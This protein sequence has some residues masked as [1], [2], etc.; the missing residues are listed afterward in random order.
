M[1]TQTTYFHQYIEEPENS[2]RQQVFLEE[3]KMEENGEYFYLN[4]N[5]AE[6]GMPNYQIGE[7]NSH[8]EV[9]DTL[10][11]LR[12]WR[13]ESQRDFLHI[14][15]SIDKG[16]NDL[17][18]QVC[19][20]QAQ[21][22]V[23]TKERN[24]LIQTVSNLSGEIAELCAKL[25]MRQP[26]PKI[27]DRCSLNTIKEESMEME[28]DDQQ[29]VERMSCISEAVPNM[30][31][32]KNEVDG[33]DDKQNETGRQSKIKVQSRYPSRSKLVQTGS[34][35]SLNDN[36]EDHICP[37]CNIAFTHLKSLRIHLKNM[38]TKHTKKRLN[39]ESPTKNEDG[40]GLSEHSVNIEAEEIQEGHRND[41]YENIGGDKKFKCRQ[42][43]YSSGYSSHIKQH[44]KAVHEK[45][46]NH[47][48]GKC[49]YAASKKG[50]LKTHIEAVHENIKHFC[51]DCGYASKDK[52]KLNIHIKAVHKNIRNNV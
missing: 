6:T 41:L 39:E 33:T 32:T 18:E 52:G 49:G 10:K 27:L 31:I 7:Y 51:E 35:H 17:V 44:I 36:S 24:D 48:C 20:L 3:P 25:D 42:C 40:K 23:T 47:V 28:D 34:K 16:I 50:N 29:Y 19:G 43:H 45:I 37:E 9:K 46:R 15:N 5:G 21:L 1:I 30:D 13:Q 2:S 38:H 12:T 11:K 22:E 26:L 4:S 8:K 14:S